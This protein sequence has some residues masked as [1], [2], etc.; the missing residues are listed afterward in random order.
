MSD[1][2]EI[3]SD[4]RKKLTSGRVPD[5]KKYTYFALNNAVRYSGVNK[6]ERLGDMQ[7]IYDTFEEVHPNGDFEDWEQ[8]YYN[9]H[10]GEERL[11][12][13]TEDAYG[14]LVKIRE[15]IKQLDKDDVRKFVEGMSLYGTYENR[16]PRQAVRRKLIQDVRGCE[17][18]EEGEW[19][20][21]EGR[22]IRILPEGKEENSDFDGIRIFYEEKE[23]ENTITINLKELNHQITDF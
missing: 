5:R 13:A 11:E 23:E 15:S 6:K 7:A 1:T 16:N 9:R 22:K 12:E 4:E 19:L 2:I 8:F 20:M 14:M 17:E 21:Y 3:D 18:V 10:E